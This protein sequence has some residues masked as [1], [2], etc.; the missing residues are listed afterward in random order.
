MSEIV[1][2]KRGFL[3][4]AAVIARGGTSAEAAT[5]AGVSARTIG[6]WRQTGQFREIVRTVRAETLRATSGQLLDAGHRATAA[7]VALLDHR[8][9]RIVLDAAGKLLAHGVRYHEVAE[10]EEAVS[11]VS[12][13]LQALEAKTPATPRD[14]H[15]N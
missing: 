10:L 3:A 13:R 4:A 12:E 2:E 6:R 14:R 7:L 11:N 8:D 5:A 1:Y 9:P 15:E